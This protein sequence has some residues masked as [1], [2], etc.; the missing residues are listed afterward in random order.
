MLRISCENLSGRFSDGVH[1]LA[2]IAGLPLSQRAALAKFDLQLA[3]HVA[4]YGG[5]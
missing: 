4:D 3:E 2:A 1:A 5:N